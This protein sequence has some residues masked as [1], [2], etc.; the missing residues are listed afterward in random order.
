MAFFLLSLRIYGNGLYIISGIRSGYDS[1]FISRFSCKSARSLLPLLLAVIAGR[2]GPH[3]MI[4]MIF[5][6]QNYFSENGA[7]FP[8][9][10][11]DFTIS[12]S[13]RVWIHKV[14][15]DLDPR[16]LA[17]SL[18][19]FFMER[20]ALAFLSNWQTVSKRTLCLDH[21]A[22]RTTVSAAVYTEG[23]WTSLYRIE[24]YAHSFSLRVCWP[25]KQVIR[26][27]WS[28]A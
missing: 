7:G 1:Y 8:T 22:V 21:L 4:V 10:S 19:R 27:N 6:T 25:Q 17:R 3:L 18:A 16:S 24:I 14:L 2:Y 13:V 15:H 23:F 5:M 28:S 9:V 11:L 26:Q 20:H 12:F